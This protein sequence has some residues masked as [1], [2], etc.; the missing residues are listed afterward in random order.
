MTEY[1]IVQIETELFPPFEEDYSIATELGY[2]PNF[3]F[4]VTECKETDGLFGKI[5]GNITKENYDEETF[6]FK[7]NRP[8]YSN[9]EFSLMSREQFKSKI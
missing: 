8:R 1:L 6:T 5:I 2:F 9:S 4:A 7:V 3:I